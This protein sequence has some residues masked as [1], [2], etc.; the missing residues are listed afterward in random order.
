MEFELELIR[1]ILTLARKI[2]ER[3]EGKIRFTC[4]EG[5]LKITPSK[6]HEML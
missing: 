1:K 6:R 4:K 2:T 3:G 5:V